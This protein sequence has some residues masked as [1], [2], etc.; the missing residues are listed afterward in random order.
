[1][2]CELGERVKWYSPCPGNKLR[3]HIGTVIEVVGAGSLPTRAGDWSVSPRKHESYV[4]E[5]VVRASK[6]TFWPRV[7]WLVKPAEEGRNDLPRKIE[8]AC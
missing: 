5:E 7:K 2:K 1:M 4:L 6:N 8:A 3:E